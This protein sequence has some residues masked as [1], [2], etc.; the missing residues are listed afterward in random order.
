M[1][2]LERGKGEQIVIGDEIEITIQRVSAAGRVWLGVNAPTDIPVDR[3][4][5]HEQKQQEQHA[6]Q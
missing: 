6:N 1:L 4:E 5:I 3:R 2:I